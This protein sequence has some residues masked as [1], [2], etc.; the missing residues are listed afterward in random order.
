MRARE[1]LAIGRSEVTHPYLLPVRLTF[2]ADKPG[3]VI[4]KDHDG[5]LD[6]GWAVVPCDDR[7]AALLVMACYPAARMPS[8]ARIERGDY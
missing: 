2:A 3:G 4:I 8:W 5:A 1:A 7:A 6:A